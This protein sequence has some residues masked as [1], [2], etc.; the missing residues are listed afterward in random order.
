M[1]RAYA[2]CL[3]TKDKKIYDK[4]VNKLEGFEHLKFR[5]APNIYHLKKEDLGFERE[6]LVYVPKVF[7]E[8]KLC[9]KEVSITDSNIEDVLEIVTSYIPA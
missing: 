7:D 8:H 3:R 1:S 6:C 5:I 2:V 4:L 9:P